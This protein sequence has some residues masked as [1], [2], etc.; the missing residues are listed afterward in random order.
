VKPLFQPHKPDDPSAPV[1]RDLD[2]SDAKKLRAYTL[3]NS[4]GKDLKLTDDQ[5]AWYLQERKQ[6]ALDAE[7][8]NNQP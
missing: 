2:P 6:K 4:I 3:L 1:H 7:E 8:A 5:L